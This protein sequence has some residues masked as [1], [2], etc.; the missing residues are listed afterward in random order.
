MI[1]EYLEVC[2]QKIR[3]R[4]LPFACTKSAVYQ[5][6]FCSDQLKHKLFQGEVD[7]VISSFDDIKVRMNSIITILDR[8]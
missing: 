3:H 2:V 6:L 5:Y 4:R 7:R 8:H 1:S